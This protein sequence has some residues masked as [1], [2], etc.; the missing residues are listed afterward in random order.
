MI[1]CLSSQEKNKEAM[2]IT[3]P[4]WSETVGKE[5][6]MNDFAIKMIVDHEINDITEKVY[7]DRSLEWLRKEIEKIK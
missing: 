1:V 4:L 3:R 5:A 6:G 7:T 2:Y